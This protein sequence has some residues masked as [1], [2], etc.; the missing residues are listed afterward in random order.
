MLPEFI[1]SWSRAV[2]EADIVTRE[3]SK[4]DDSNRFDKIFFMVLSPD[5]RD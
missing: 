5:S 4:K 3:V 1:D 2:G